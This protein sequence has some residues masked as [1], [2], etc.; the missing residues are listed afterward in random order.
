LIAITAYGDDDHRRRAYE[1]GF[2]HFLTKPM[3]S[4]TLQRLLASVS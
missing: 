2:D 3:S 1:S 4:D